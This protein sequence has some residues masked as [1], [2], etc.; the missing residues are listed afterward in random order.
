MRAPTSQPQQPAEHGE[1]GHAHG[2]AMPRG[3]AFV[4]AVP[5]VIG[6]G[7]LVSA[8]V[9]KVDSPRP[10]YGYGYAYAPY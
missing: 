3:R 10:V 2:P 9:I 4:M 1:S 6:L 5:L 7:L 8:C